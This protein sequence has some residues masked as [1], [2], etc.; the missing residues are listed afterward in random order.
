MSGR[1]Y[2]VL[3]P[4]GGWSSI[5]G[6]ESRAIVTAFLL[7]VDYRRVAVHSVLCGEGRSLF[8]WLSLFS[9]RDGV[10]RRSRSLCCA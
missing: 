4:K 6:S 9:C 5:V 1:W 7:A 3:S 10:T 2:L 8:F